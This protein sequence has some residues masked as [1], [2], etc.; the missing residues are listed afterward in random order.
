MTWRRA[1]LIAAAL[2][3]VGAAAALGLLRAPAQEP[4]VVAPEPALAEAP[5]PPPAPSKPLPTL[6]IAVKG[7]AGVE[8]KRRGAT[9]QQGCASEGTGEPL[10]PGQYD[11]R[12]VAPGQVALATVRLN[13]GD[14]KRLELQLQP[15]AKLELLVL[16]AE[17]LPVDRVNVV[18]QHGPSGAVLKG[19][20]DSDGTLSFEP[21]VPGEWWISAQRDGFGPGAGV[22]TTGK[23]LEL[24]LGQVGVLAGQLEPPAAGVTL[25]LLTPERALVA[26]AVTDGGG[27]VLGLVPHGRYRLRAQSRDFELREEEVTVP[28][29][30]P[31]TVRLSSGATVKG[32]LVGPAREK[33]DGDVTASGPGPSRTVAARG[34]TFEVRGLSPGRWVLSSGAGSTAVSIDGGVMRVELV[35]PKWDGV[36]AGTCGFD[37]GHRMPAT[38]LVRAQSVTAACDG[39]AFELTGLQRGFY[40]LEVEASE[41]ASR[42]TSTAGAAATGTRDVRVVVPGVA[43]LTYRL[44]DANGAVL[45]THSREHY[46]DRDFDLTLSAPGH[47]ATPKMVSL[48]RGRDTALGDLVLAPGVTVKGRVLDAVT[49]DPISGVTVLDHQTV[50]DGTFTLREAPAGETELRFTHPRYVP[51]VVRVTAP[52]EVAV[53]LKPA[54]RAVGTLITASGALPGRLDVWAISEHGS[55]LVPAEDGTFVT[56]HLANGRWL[57]R[58]VGEGASAYEVAELDVKSGGDRAVTLVERGAGVSFDVEV[59]SGDGAALASDV[60]LVARAASAPANDEEL[61]RLLRKPGL[62]GDAT[63]RPARYRFS[64]VPPGAYTVLASARGRVWTHAVPVMVQAGMLPVSVTFPHVPYSP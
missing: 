38:V 55:Q 10:C 33:L 24:R 28:A 14:A 43:R 40:D 36:I 39:G 20:T 5:E 2:C 1:L 27:F 56:E 18:A 35:V 22:A 12:A 48:V 45:S 54:A 42:W 32:D 62:V 37:G 31:L 25:E 51:E 6:A 8:V 52:G 61:Q 47:V 57:F 46:E 29:P 53:E 11:V 7:D 4:A 21:V 17:K 58:V 16:D 13:R 63:E 30:A 19:R 9:S 64:N 23:R 34:G 41:G 59:R 15:A 3:V 60:L 50:E 44:V 26:E 49:K